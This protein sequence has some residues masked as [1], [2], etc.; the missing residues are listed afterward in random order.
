MFNKKYLII[1]VVLTL[2]VIAVTQIVLSYSVQMKKSTK[3]ESVAVR[4][5]GSDIASDGVIHSESEATIHFQS[6]GKLVY[7]PFKIGDS[8]SQGATIAQL[9][10]YTLQRQLTQA[11]N[12]YKSTRDTFDQTQQNAQDNQLQSKQ[13]SSVN[14]A[15]MDKTNAI[16]DIV[17]RVVDQNQ[18][19]L[20]NSVINVELA[21]YALQLSTLSAPFSGIIS[22]ED[23]TVPNVNVTS[24]TS[25]SIAD[26]KNLV[27]RANISPSDID[28]VNVGAQV[29][30]SVAGQSKKFIGSVEKI[31]PQQISVNGQNV[32]PVDISSTQLSTVAKLGQQGSVLIK[33]SANI[34]TVLVPTWTILGHNSVWVLENNKPILKTVTVGKSHVDSIE[35]LDGLS[36]T[37][38]VSFNPQSIGADSYNAL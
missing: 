22:A 5:V 30:I 38:R 7:L 28:F 9:D 37:D 25:F 20:D 15:A 19:T 26:P 24:S 31:Y 12:S 21:N 29:N 4:S 6:G 33:S 23:V 1:V 14:N 2:A 36:S 17:K 8:V 11:L 32:Y 35:I 13:L 18:A 34:S 27:M 16:N 3:T 10:T